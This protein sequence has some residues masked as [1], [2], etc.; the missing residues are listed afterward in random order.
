MVGKPDGDREPTL[1]VT[2]GGKINVRQLVRDLGLR[3]TLEVPA[4][5]RAS[6]RK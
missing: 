3:E 2:G 4:L 6:I 1:P 5:S